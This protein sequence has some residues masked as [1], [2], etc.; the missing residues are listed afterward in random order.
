MPGSDHLSE[1]PR[2]PLTY[3]VTPRQWLAIDVAASVLAILVIA[4]GL[5]VWHGPRFVM[6]TAGVAAASVA[7][8][9]PV[10]VRRLW[11]LPVLAVVT[12]AVA[13]LTAVGRAPLTSDVMLG[14]ASYM[15]A[16]RL[17]RLR[18]VA[19]LVAAEGAI[20]AGLLTAAATAHT[21]NVMLHSMLACA[22]MWFTG[23]GV[24][25]RRRYQAGL[26]DQEAQRQRAEAER[27]RH[28]LAEERLRIARELHD[29]LA[30]SLSVVTVQAGVGRK[31]GAARPAEA[32]RAL[33]SVEDA[34]RGALDEVRRVLCLLRSDDEP[35]GSPA[36]TD[37]AGVPA[38]DPAL[39]PA[40]GL[41]DLD[42]LAAT[43]RT[44]GIPVRV[45]L[46]GDAAAV[47]PAAA[48]TAYR[49]VQEAL[50][51]VVRHAPGAEAAVRVG[52][53]PAGVR[54]R[55]TDTGRD[56]WAGP[57]D[58]ADGD[59]TARTG[60]GGHGIAG[61][62]ERAAIFGGTLEAGPLPGQGFQVTAFLPAAPAAAGR[63][64]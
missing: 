15:A 61:M 32:L 24:R 49:I 29:V 20:F 34:S 35:G 21:Q 53:S 3:R 37:G 10:A 31:V 41:G 44:A 30:H 57:A 55:V 19:S 6:P 47:P 39:A 45:V 27:G 16:V 38:P 33:R 46:T 40:P 1:A 9:L 60:T 51:N 22:A 2:P 12:T 58:P 4:F 62:R 43:V 8:S 52:I 11:P 54:I 56:P 42:G 7:A 25:E 5:R 63:V 50:T 36:I 26:A 23:S 14:M 17:P 13:A 48:L 64:A 28:A 18:A 59:V